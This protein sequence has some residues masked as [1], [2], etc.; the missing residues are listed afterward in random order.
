MPSN[1]PNRTSSNVNVTLGRSPERLGRTFPCPLCMTQLELRQS[2]AKKPYCVCN[3]CGVQLFFRGRKGI[4]KLGA[5]SA[6]TGIPPV[7]T[8]FLGAAD[9]FSHLERLRAHRDDLKDKRP[10]IFSDKD[11]E[12]AI[13]AISVEIARTQQVLERFANPVLD[14]GRKK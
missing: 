14:T 9:A 13:L 5:F 1:P 2:R 4:A 6:H 3:S 10:L 8:E 12:N 7:Q 11:L